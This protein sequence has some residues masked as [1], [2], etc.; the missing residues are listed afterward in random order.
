MNEWDGVAQIVNPKFAVPK[1]SGNGANSI[2][3]IFKEY[4]GGTWTGP[5]DQSSAVQFAYD[6]ENLYLGIVVT[7]DYQDNATHS[8]WNGDSVQV[9]IANQARDTI[10]ALYNYA[11]GDVEGAIDSIIVMNESGPGGTQA[12]FSRD[13]ANKTTYYEIRMPT[14]FLGLTKLIPE[15]KFG[16]GLAINDGDKL[17]PGQRGWSGLGAH[18]IVYGKSSSET[19]LLTLGADQTLNW[20]FPTNNAMLRLGQVYSLT[21]TAAADCP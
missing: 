7:D 8:G 1:G 15:T 20:V 19:A 21:A 3:V 11:L 13:A 18:S 6:S 2:Y 4:G 14:G 12:V 5:D 10:V 16:L 9:M 17:T